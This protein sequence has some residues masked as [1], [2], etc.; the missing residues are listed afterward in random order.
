MRAPAVGAPN[1]SETRRSLESL[2]AP[3]EGEGEGEG[4]GGTCHRVAEADEGD[5]GVADSVALKEIST[6]SLSSSAKGLVLGL[7]LG[8]N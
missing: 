5:R 6:D 8:L 2:G 4:G 7:G 3:G 1:K